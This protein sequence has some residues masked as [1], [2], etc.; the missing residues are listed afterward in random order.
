ML[1]GAQELSN[2][3]Y[4]VRLGLR[5][6]FVL[7]LNGEINFFAVDFGVMRRFNTKSHLAA[8]YLDHHDLDIIINR[9]TFAEFPSEY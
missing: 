1:T 6:C 8:L 3:F 9:N 5:S 4:L 2:F 7:F